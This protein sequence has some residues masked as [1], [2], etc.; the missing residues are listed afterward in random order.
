ML[1]WA[2]TPESA[3]YC[4]E[5]GAQA[6]IDYTQPDWYEEVKSFTGGRGADVIYDPVGG[7]VFDLSTQVHSRPTAGCSSSASPAGRVR[8]YPAN[9]LLLKNFSA[10]GVYWERQADEL[11]PISQ[12][13][14]AALTDLFLEGS[15]IRR[16]TGPSRSSRRGRPCGRSRAGACSARSC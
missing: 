9:R 2:S 6:T 3:P 16:S 12:Q 8:R 1:A 10:V 4:Q 7:G 14:H 15:S 5:H 11:I 13:A